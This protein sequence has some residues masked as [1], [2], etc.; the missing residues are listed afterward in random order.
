MYVRMCICM[1]VCA[2]VCTYVA[3]ACGSFTVSGPLYGD[4][5]AVCGYNME[6]GCVRRMAD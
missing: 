4:V 5:A 1:Y 2:Y 3:A 6:A